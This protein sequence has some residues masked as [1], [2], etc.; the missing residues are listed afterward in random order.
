MVREIWVNKYSEVTRATKMAEKCSGYE[1]A[2]ALRAGIA[3]P[4]LLGP[5][6]AP[7]AE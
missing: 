4:L 5:P 2:A 3:L 1:S 6:A 7:T